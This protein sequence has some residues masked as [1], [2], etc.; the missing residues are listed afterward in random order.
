MPSVGRLHDEVDLRIIDGVSMAD[1]PYNV[2]FLCTG[3]SARSILAESLIK[4]D[5]IGK[6]QPD[7]SDAV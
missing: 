1:R 5:A 4:V 3:N 2:L 7:G 6:M